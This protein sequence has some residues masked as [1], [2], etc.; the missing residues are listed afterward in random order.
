MHLF[1]FF[2]KQNICLKYYTRNICAR[3]F[4]RKYTIKGYHRDARV[5][6]DA[7]KFGIKGF[8]RA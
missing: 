4:P 7:D 3:R 2:L 6:W 8:E 5:P 1:N